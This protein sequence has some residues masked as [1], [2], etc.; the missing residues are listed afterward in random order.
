MQVASQLGLG[1]HDTSADVSHD[2][3]APPSLS[4]SHI[5]QILQLVSVDSLPAYSTLLAKMLSAE[6]REI[7]RGAVHT[8]LR[9][10]QTSSPLERTAL[11]IL[12]RL[13][14]LCATHCARDTPLGLITG[15]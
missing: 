4:G 12:N 5:V 13:R 9:Q 2:P 6:L 8:A 7:P 3:E 11:S 15:Q 10:A 14:S 1:S